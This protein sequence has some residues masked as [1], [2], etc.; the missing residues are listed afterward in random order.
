MSLSVTRQTNSKFKNDLYAVDVAGFSTRICFN[1]Y[2]VVFQAICKYSDIKNG[3][4]YAN[5]YG[6]SG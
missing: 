5:H 3:Q 6:S 2:V 1:P 4:K